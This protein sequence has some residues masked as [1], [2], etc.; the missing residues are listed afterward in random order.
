MKNL[1]LLFLI[2]F[3]SA[4]ATNTPQHNG[5]LRVE[6]HQKKSYNEFEGVWE[7]DGVQE[8]TS[9]W[10]IKVSILDNNYSIDYPSLRCGGELIL[11]SEGSGRMEFREQLTY[12]KTKCIDNG[13]TALIIV[14]RDSVR[15]EWYYPNGKMGATGTLN[16][17]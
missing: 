2:F 10:T 4:C 11:I 6:S 9:S 7:G 5:E 8:N 12:G 17:N 14:G 13:R 3:V 15:F 1:L 16:R